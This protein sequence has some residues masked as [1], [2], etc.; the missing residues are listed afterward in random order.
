MQGS[1][2]IVMLGTA[3]G[4]PSGIASVMQAYAANGLFQRWHAVYLPTHRDGTRANKIAIALG[5]WMDLV[6]RLMAGRVALLH[7]HLAS[8]ASFWRKLLFAVPASVLRVPYIL[9]VHGGAFL[10]FYDSQNAISQRIIRHR[11]RNAARVIALSTEWKDVLS[12]IEPRARI[13]VIANPV[14]VPAWRATL[15]AQPPTALFLGTI[16]E[17][18]GVADLLRAWPTVME[19]IPEAQLV[20]AGG[21]DLAMARE[22]ARQLGAEGSVRIEG[23]VEGEAKDHLLRR[24]S[25]F[26]L[27]SHVEA[28]PMALLEAL[29]AGLPA[30]ASRV[31]GIPSAVTD[32]RQGLLVE[33]RDTSGIAGALILLLRDLA[34]RKA[35]GRAARERMVAEF[36]SEV[37][38]PR[39]EAI[40]RELAPAQ[41]VR[42]RIPAA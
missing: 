32:Q 14:E 3:P 41:E 31:G 11:L 29:A 27:P 19:A 33:P 35:M 28:L 22:L 23:W 39:V 12:G 15:E 40:W 37:I 9:H 7:I 34:R 36:S 26:V 30:V 16:V 6:A 1:P 4:M 38:V 20:V 8:Y 24:A 17:R 42:A 18:K 21:G 25:V 2:Q 13:E 5:A 10:E